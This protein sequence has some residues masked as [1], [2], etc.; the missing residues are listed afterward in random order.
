[1]ERRRFEKFD[2]ININSFC[3]HEERMTFTQKIIDDLNQKLSNGWTI[4]SDTT[5]VVCSHFQEHTKGR[6]RPLNYLNLRY[7]A[8]SGN[9]PKLYRI[10]LSSIS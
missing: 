4:F 2:N 1:M 6:L 10:V 3:T 9:F 8:G 7:R 5:R